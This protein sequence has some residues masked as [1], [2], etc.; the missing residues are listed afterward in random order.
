MTQRPKLSHQPR[1]PARQRPSGEHCTAME[2]QH[3]P[4]GR[5][6]QL[7]A[8]SQ[9]PLGRSD[10][11]PRTPG[12]KVQGKH[13]TRSCPFK[14]P[15]R[16]ASR[17]ES[18]G[19]RARHLAGLGDCQPPRRPQRV[20]RIRGGCCCPISCTQAAAPDP[21]EVLLPPPGGARRTVAP[22]HAAGS[23]H[24]PG[25]PC[26]GLEPVSEMDCITAR[27]NGL[28]THSSHPAGHSSFS[29]ARG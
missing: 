3:F 5:H 13:T 29:A 18:P 16:P 12:A 10:K 26:R 19:C 1:I 15:R 25:S 14:Q 22:G 8:K 4:G 9:G 24:L 21:R 2:K 27:R 7:P 20:R 23:T 11:E 28:F 6:V 17:T